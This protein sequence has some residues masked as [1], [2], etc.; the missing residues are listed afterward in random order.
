MTK[1]YNKMLI[2]FIIAAVMV[3]SA[4]AALTPGAYASSLSSGT[5]TYNPTTFGLTQSGTPIPTVA[6]VS[7]GSFPSGSTVY[8]YLSSTDSYSGLLSDNSIAYAILNQSSPTSLNQAVKFF[9]TS[10]GLTLTNGKTYYILATN[11]APP[12]SAANLAT[13]SWAFPATGST[14]VTDYANFQV[15]NPQANNA[16]ATGSGAL[17]VG[18]TAL[19]FGEHWD[20]GATVNVYLNYPGSS[21]LLVT[22]TANSFGV[23]EATFTVPNLAGT[24][25]TGSNSIHPSY[26]VI[27]QESNAYSS[28]D[29]QGGLTV[30]SSM[31]IAPAITVTPLDNSGAVGSSLTIS[32]TGFPAGQTVA[33]NSIT[34]TTPAGVTIDTKSLAAT[35]SSNGLFTVTVTLVNAISGNQN[36][37]AEQLNIPFKFSTPYSSTSSPDVFEFPAAFF[38]SSPNPQEL[39]FLF[40]VYGYQNNANVTTPVLAAV[41]DFPASA[42]VSIMIGSTVVG[43][44]TT[45]SNGFGMLP[46]T[47][48]VPAM[49]AGTYTVTAVDNSQHLVA[50]P[51]NAMYGNTLVKQVTIGSIY[52][53]T[54]VAGNPLMIND[55]S[56]ST[57]EYVPQLGT[58]NVTAYGLSPSDV[59]TVNDSSTGLNVVA[60][61]MVSK[62]MVGTENAAGTFIYPAANGTIEL[63]YTPYY[64]YYGVTTGTPAI[65]NV[66]NGTGNKN[67]SGFWGMTYGYYEIG[68]PSIASTPQVVTPGNS[69]TVTVSNIIPSS[70]AYQPQSFYPG[71]TNYYNIYLG[72]SELKTSTASV[73]GGSAMSGLV[74]NV[75]AL[76]SGV[77]NLSI[78][79]ASQPLSSAIALQQSAFEV[80]ST[81]GAS[82]GSGSLVIGSMQ[83]GNQF[84]G[85]YIAG[86]GMLPNQV[87]SL[88]IYT[89]DGPVVS[90]V[91]SSTDSY[92]AFLD[93]QDLA[94]SGSIMTNDVAGTYSVVLSMSQLSST[95]E[96]T[97][98]YSV[99][100]SI[101][102]TQTSK[103]INDGFYGGAFH[104]Q[105]NDLVTVSAYNLNPGTY[106]SLYFG[107]MFMGDY[108]ASSVNPS[109]FAQFTVPVA[110]YGQYNVSIYQASNGKLVAQAPFVIIP[111]YQTNMSLS[112][113]QGVPLEY[114]FP[115][116]I[117]NFM[118]TP[119]FTPAKVS[120]VSSVSSITV[121]FA[122]NGLPAGTT[123]SVTL[124]GTTEAS[125]TNEIAFTESVSSTALD[126]S[127][128]SV[129]GY[130]AQPSSGSV[131]PVNSVTITVTFQKVTTF[132]A[133]FT[134]TG[135]PA[136]TEWWMGMEVSGTNSV[137]VL[138]STT[139]TI[140]FPNLVNG[141]T[142]VFND[143][144]SGYVGTPS[145][146]QFTINSAN[147]TATIAFSLPYAVTFFQTG[148]PSGTS[149]TITLYNNTTMA[150]VAKG[151][152]T[153]SS[154]TIYAA[155]TPS[156]Y[157]YVWKVSPV[158][159]YAANYTQGWVV[160]ASTGNTFSPP[161]KGHI[162]F[163]PPVAVTFT[164]SG[165]SSGTAWEIFIYDTNN[166]FVTSN[167]STS[168]TL[169]INLYGSSPGTTYYWEADPVMGY[170]VTY[171]SSDTPSSSGSYEI[172]VIET[173]TSGTVTSAYFSGPTAVTFTPALTF[174]DQSQYTLNLLTITVQ[175]SGSSANSPLSPTGTSYEYNLTAVSPSYYDYYV[176]SGDYYSYEITAPS[177][178]T[179][180]PTAGSFIMTS[181]PYYVYVTITSTKTYTVNFNESGLPSGLTWYVNM[182][183]N[184]PSDNLSATSPSPIQF[185]EYNGTY[186]YSVYTPSGYNPTVSLGTVV[187]N[188]KNVWMT[189]YFVQTSNIVT[190]VESGLPAVPTN[191]FVVTFAGATYK[192][193]SNV[194]TITTQS[195]PN[196]VY[197]FTVSTVSDYYPS[198]ASGTV[199][200]I[201]Q[202]IL[203]NIQFTTSPTSSQSSIPSTELRP[204]NVQ[205]LL[206][207]TVYT[208]IF[209]ATQVMSSGTDYIGGTFMLPNAAPGTYWGVQLEWYYPVYSD[210]AIT[211][212]PTAPTYYVSHSMSYLQLVT[213]N[214]SILTGISSAEVASIQ[215][216]ITGTVTASLQV[217]LSELNAAVLEI[218]N[219]T[220]LIK[221][222]FGLM[223][224]SLSALNAS[225]SGISSGFA[226]LNTKLGNISVALNELNASIVAVNGG[227]VT[228]DT[229]LGTISTSLGNLNATV[230]NISNGVA[231]LNTAA[232][233]IQLSLTSINATLAGIVNG[234]A[235]LNTSVGQV[236]TSLTTI[237]GQITAV[238]GNIATVQTS[239]G[240]VQTSLSSL[241]ATVTS[242]NNGVAT[243]QTSLGT[244]TGTVTSINNGVAT[245]QTN[246]G[247]LQ[248]SVNGVGNKVSTVGQSVG[249]TMIFEVVVLILV[250]I[251]LVLAFLSMSNSNKLAKKLD[252]MKKQ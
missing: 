139:S 16:Q 138:S 117:V 217:P 171:S 136:G 161:S 227:I 45:D 140:V 174:I 28:T 124:G 130:T 41:Y 169:T 76:G 83:V 184:I 213:G 67:I 120:A 42:S 81:Y 116:E 15:Q 178:Y 96:F 104:D 198:P 225:I 155:S 238:N 13:L 122:E 127:V 54:D 239:L 220:A 99:Q 226:N 26:N 9:S 151:T 172:T 144:A 103:N 61:G 147:F 50:V 143:S 110:P 101:Q 141:E 20:P 59:Y 77:Y 8:F 82:L 173:V 25:D 208:T 1:P 236:K 206:N 201:G 194:Q 100:S 186:T 58:V 10:I 219:S 188:G 211:I 108:V 210:S 241:N 66:Y 195:L 73:F 27:A 74:F 12:L 72:S 242:I 39:G 5:V 115:G 107:S 49:P 203:V 137:N 87:F 93:T 176:T 243:V 11:A 129:S 216:A 181:T 85:Y 159:G 221:T 135:L 98:A 51:T 235:V 126:F 34:I 154:L 84:S 156:N 62:V 245:I 175:T 232:G 114:A 228:I 192:N 106:Y 231:M 165:L 109:S 6:Y 240:T 246:L 125:S 123:W 33:A 177:G 166:N 146:G 80:V 132:S 234:M 251:T 131:Y 36:K 158:S 31:D 88:T 164:E 252:E 237:S 35:V 48:T 190:F 105:I 247:T 63:S 30:D 142:Y 145:G 89:S 209:N 47:T 112:S 170:Y 91:A 168:T 250:L 32:G 56:S 224:A 153:G 119:M 95:Y 94:S 128:P 230:M 183:S 29:V 133:K 180:S 52:M 249:N 134:E 191:S 92:G 113:A 167:S 205:V 17:Q 70:G 197:S 3:L 86:F 14:F 23:F 102:F 189:V 248:T 182:P 57:N 202:G 18:Q 199:D 162:G 60:N 244:L 43:N 233:K 157:G 111:D 223:T 163:S 212:T 44:I 148:L 193:E 121:T 55:G 46:L 90:T 38:V 69:I 152:S 68:A 71:T 222:D 214:G 200:L 4:L 149:W 64:G 215:S 196:G 21:V 187:V 207:G 160:V 218:N 7:G 19:A 2:T 179:V 97:A 24:V 37:G 229:S 150:Y 22:G 79:Y 78:T 185:T 118:W 204:V 65:V 40:S 75:P 53:V